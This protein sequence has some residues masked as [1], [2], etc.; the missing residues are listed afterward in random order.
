MNASTVLHNSGHIYIQVINC[1]S[2]PYSALTYCRQY[3]ID[4]M[5]LRIFCFSFSF[6]L[7]RGGMICCFRF[8]RSFFIFLLFFLLCFCL[9]TSPDTFQ[10][11]SITLT[12][13]F[14][15]EW[16]PKNQCTDCG[17]GGSCDVR[18][19]YFDFPL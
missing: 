17:D 12:V 13:R 19:C 14:V 8:F 10:S 3:L 6:S 18:Y 5:V 11:L 1:L 15:I 16:A 2:V 9:L 7:D 4:S